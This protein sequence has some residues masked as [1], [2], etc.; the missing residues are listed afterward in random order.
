VRSVHC[1][2][3]AAGHAARPA[4]PDSR[5]CS[6]GSSGT[7]AGP[8]RSALGA[9]SVASAVRARLA[10]SCAISGPPRPAW[11]A[12]VQLARLDDVGPSPARHHA[13]GTCLPDSHQRDGAR[14]GPIG[15]RL[16][17]SDRAESAE[18]PRN[19]RHPADE[20]VR[21]QPVTGAASERQCSQIS[22]P[23]G[24]AV[25]IGWGTEQVPPDRLGRDARHGVLQISLAY[26]SAIGIN[27]MTKRPIIPQRRKTHLLIIAD[28]AMQENRT[29]SKSP[30]TYVARSA[31]Y[32]TEGSAP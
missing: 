16:L 31:C 25:S 22:E 13:R 30:T 10:R 5:P 4:P 17:R 20:V 11:A 19:I 3:E 14:R 21:Q 24:V 23:S 6:A 27:H 26:S 12:G 7:S 2:L 1:R 9:S 8:R 18:W 15:D 32:R 29:P 28:D